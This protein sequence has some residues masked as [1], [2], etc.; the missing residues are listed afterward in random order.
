[1]QSR[2]LDVVLLQEAGGRSMDGEAF[3]RALGDDLGFHVAY[4]PA[5]PV[6]EGESPT[7]GLAIVSRYPLGAVRVEPLRFNQLR[8]RSRCRIALTAT[9]QT[10]DGPVGLVNVH[11]DTRISRNERVA[12]LKPLLDEIRDSA[13][14][15]IVGGDF[16]TQSVQWV[17]S[18]WP[19]PFT[20]GQHAAVHE[21]MTSNGFETPFTDT[22]STLS[23]FG[24]PQKL[25]WMYLRGLTALTWA[26]DEVRYSDHRGIWAQ[27]RRDAA[28]VPAR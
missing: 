22:P 11:L 28:P 6:D 27:V 14:P 26:V 10:P 17:R 5:F 19:I 24:L 9:V 25:D 16:N 23:F 4:A 3:A 2:A 12:Q 21:L 8:F 1:V 18:T 15:Q 20:G 13:I 7:Q